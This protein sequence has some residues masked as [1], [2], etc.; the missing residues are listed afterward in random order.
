MHY[1][2]ICRYNAHT[3]HSLA[4]MLHHTTK[5]DTMHY[6]D[7]CRY[8]AHTVHSLAYM[9]HHKTK[10]DTT[11]YYIQ[12]FQQISPYLKRSRNII[13]FIYQY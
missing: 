1:N 10:Q 4:Y 11:D 3:V 12:A 8:N 7:I 5:Q 6:N 2:D 9:L 13:F